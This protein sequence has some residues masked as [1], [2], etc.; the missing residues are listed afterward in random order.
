M[1]VTQM[2][3]ASAEIRTDVRERT[4]PSF[5][6]NYHGIACCPESTHIMDEEI[7]KVQVYLTSLEKD[8]LPLTGTSQYQNGIEKVKRIALGILGLE[9]GG[10]ALLPLFIS[11]FKSYCSVQLGRSWTSSPR[12]PYPTTKALQSVFI[13]VVCIHDSE[14]TEPA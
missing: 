5:L 8:A 7:N 4:F 3:S 9:L 13:A 6:E 12:A 14:E 2:P 11:F 1:A 10:Q